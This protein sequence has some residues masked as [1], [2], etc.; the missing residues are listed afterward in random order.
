MP[1]DFE[2]IAAFLFRLASLWDGCEI[3]T[4]ICLA[5]RTRVGPNRLVQTTVSCPYCGVVNTIF[6]DESAGESQTYVED[7]QVCCQPWQVTVIVNENGE[8][9][10]DA[11]KGGD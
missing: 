8:P 11:R 1:S 10:V 2:E 9:E 3:N 5:C 7:C 4:Q 6:V